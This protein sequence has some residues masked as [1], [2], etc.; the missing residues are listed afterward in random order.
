MG[1]DFTGG[2]TA[3]GYFEGTGSY[4]TPAWHVRCAATGHRVVEVNPGRP[5]HAPWPPRKSD[6]PR[7]LSPDAALDRSGD[8]IRRSPI[9]SSG[10]NKRIRSTAVRLERQGDRR[11][12]TAVLAARGESP[13]IA[14]H[15][16]ALITG[17]SYQAFLTG[18]AMAIGDRNA[19][20]A[21]RWQKTGS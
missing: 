10:C 4:G 9:L 8:A 1:R 16:H 15:R 11:L 2:L 12:T 19:A 7:R 6:H 20:R 18:L 21:M 3:F 14:Q 17:E 5:A 13:A